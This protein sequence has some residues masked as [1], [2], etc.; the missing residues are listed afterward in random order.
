MK[1][2]LQSIDKY[3]GNSAADL[4]ISDYNLRKLR[5]LPNVS[6]IRWIEGI[7]LV[8]RPGEG[9]GQLRIGEHVFNVT[10]AWGGRMKSGGG[11][12]DRT[13]YTVRIE[14]V[15]AALKLA[16]IRNQIVKDENKG[17]LNYRTRFRTYCKKYDNK[18]LE[19]RR[20]SLIDLNKWIRESSTERTRKIKP[21]IKPLNVKKCLQQHQRAWKKNDWVVLTY[22]MKIIEADMI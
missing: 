16:D 2:F 6:S 9:K 20:Q 13:S 4:H 5:K 11:W 1:Y 8:I 21:S 17:K 18:T 15:G 14:G 22:S 10:Y 12:A 19:Q 7:N 3:D